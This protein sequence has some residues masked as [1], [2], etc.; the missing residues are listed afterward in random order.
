ME[1]SPEGSRDDAL[2]AG[3][4]AGLAK[5]SFAVPVDDDGDVELQVELA[6]LAVVGRQTL[7]KVKIL[8]LRLPTHDLLGIADG[9][10]QVRGTS[11]DVGDDCIESLGASLIR[12]K[13]RS[14][15]K[16]RLDDKR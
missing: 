3:A 16:R 12:G 1:I 11:D 13:V 14:L 4:E 2:R 5:I 6:Q 9:A 10:A 8:V 7:C 15:L